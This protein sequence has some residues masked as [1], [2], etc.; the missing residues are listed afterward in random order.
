MGA[1]LS[2]LVKFWSRKIGLSDVAVVD[3]EVPF[4]T[5]AYIETQ[6][7]TATN[8]SI[9]TLHIDD[10][11]PL[12]ASQSPQATPTTT[13]GDNPAVQTG[14][15]PSSFISAN[16]VTDP[17]LE[18]CNCNRGRF[19]SVEAHTQCLEE[20]CD[21]H[22]PQRHMHTPRQFLDWAKILLTGNC[23]PDSEY[24]RTRSTLALYM[25]PLVF[26]EQ[27]KVL[28]RQN[29]MTKAWTPPG[30]SWVGEL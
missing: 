25:V 6:C 19:H 21:R 15:P 5:D 16:P 29:P 28:L 4:G 30:T 17:E 7:L 3:A 9:Q 23:A 2:K 8:T 1:L 27:N 24:R 20:P 12:L 11:T 10:A 14:S 26:D 18:I 22:G 13:I